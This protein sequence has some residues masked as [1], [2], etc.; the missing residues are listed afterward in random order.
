MEKVCGKF[1]NEVRL[2]REVSCKGNGYRTAG[3][4]QDGLFYREKCDCELYRPQESQSTKPS[5]N[6]K[7]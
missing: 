2:G 4:C 1:K 3:P 5:G 7:G 6:D